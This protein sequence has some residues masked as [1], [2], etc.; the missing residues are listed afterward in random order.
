M[1]TDLSPPETLIQRTGSSTAADYNTVGQHFL[2]IFVK[3]GGIKPTDRVLDVGCGC[4]R[5][6]L[7]LTR[8]LTTGSYEG[9]DIS[10]D[11][12]EW[13]Q[14]NIAARFPNFKFQLTDVYNSEYNPRGKR[15]AEDYRFPYPDRSFDFTF[16]TSVFT[17]MLPHDLG[18]YTWEIAR[19]LKPRGRAVITFFILNEESERLTKMQPGQF[20]FQHPYADGQIRVEKRSNP[21]GAV[22]YPEATVRRVLE[23]SGLTLLEPIYFGQWYGR[24]G[25]ITFQDL[26]VSERKSTFELQRLAHRIFSWSR[27]RFFYSSRKANHQERH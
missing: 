21:E 5:M 24:N 15:K 7:P 9:F 19:T 12:I 14:K 6:A 13:C 11:A 1:D 16:V 17:H 20:S 10:G 25:T 23:Q 27:S 4:G 26:T 3:Y 2:E 8:Y 18:R 22:G